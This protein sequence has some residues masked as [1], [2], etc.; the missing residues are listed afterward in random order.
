MLIDFN[1]IQIWLDFHTHE[2]YYL[3]RNLNAF[4]YKQIKCDLRLSRKQVFPSTF[5]P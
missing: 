2:I 4:S 5:P 1:L 3:S